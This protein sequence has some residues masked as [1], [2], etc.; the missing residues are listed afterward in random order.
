[1]S[2]YNDIRPTTLDQVVGQDNIKNQLKGVIAS[3]NIPNAFLLTGP[4]G[5]GKTTI[6]RIIARTLNCEKGG[7]EPCGECK[8]CKEIMSGTSYDVIEMD[9]A[10]NNKVEDVRGIIEKAQYAPMS[11]Y[12]VFILDEVHMFSSGAWNALLKLIEEPPVGVVFILCTT[13]EHKVPATIISRCRKFYF[14]KIDLNVISDYL[15]SVCESYGKAYDEDALKLIAQA[16]EGCMRD[17]LSIM[18]SFFDTDTLITDMVANTLGVSDEDAVFGILNAIS[19][20]DAGKAISIVR[21]QA[22]RGKSAQLLVKAIIS[23][24]TDTMFVLNGTD[25]TSVVNT[26][27]YKQLLGEYAQKTDMVRCLELSKALGEVYGTLTKVPDALFLIESS[28]I[29]VIKV[30]SNS[31]LPVDRLNDIE[32]RLVALEKGNVSDVVSESTVEEIKRLEEK[33]ASLG[34]VQLPGYEKGDN[35]L[36]AKSSNESCGA[37]MPSQDTNVVDFPATNNEPTVDESNGIAGIEMPVEIENSSYMDI[38][39]DIPFPEDEFFIPFDE[40]PNL[41]EKKPV[42][43]TSTEVEEPTAPPTISVEQPA[44]QAETV[45]VAQDDDIFS[46][47]PQ[48]TTIVNNDTVAETPAP[49]PTQNEVVSAESVTESNEE[50]PLVGKEEPVIK[51]DDGL[52]NIGFNGFADWL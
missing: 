16:S 10:S 5:T 7:E 22:K 50:T 44:Q 25:A 2:L 32:R 30:E 33:I 21:E 1:M 17:A 26:N 51:S 19:N 43:E 48:G 8:S 34:L 47:L 23:A 37:E 27:K 52:T 36:V 9:A 49:T 28:L 35:V 12:K 14:Q 45:P 11:K 18:E 3:G 15:G 20:A 13:E 46:H 38:G 6:A 24:V 42:V 39:N 4:R 41:V 31:N 40:N 29:R